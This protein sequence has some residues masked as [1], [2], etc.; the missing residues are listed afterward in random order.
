MSWTDAPKLTPS[1]E[2]D[3]KFNALPPRD[4]ALVLTVT[5]LT[6]VAYEE[7]VNKPEESHFKDLSHAMTRMVKHTATL[8]TVKLIT[9]IVAKA[10]ATLPAHMQREDFVRLLLGSLEK[11]GTMGAQKADEAT[12]DAMRLIALLPNAKHYVGR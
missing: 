7:G 11:A 8:D 9:Q 6:S 10:Q 4:M 3:R 2:L 5:T 12:V 1:E